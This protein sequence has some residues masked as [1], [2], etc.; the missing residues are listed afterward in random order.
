MS[1]LHVTY[2]CVA[3]LGRILAS[4]TLTTLLTVLTSATVTSIATFAVNVQSLVIPHLPVI[5]GMWA[6]ARNHD[7]LR[8]VGNVIESNSNIGSRSTVCRIRRGSTVIA[9]TTVFRYGGQK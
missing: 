6:F 1:Q 2:R 5:A 4:R 7:N 9:G 8:L 3:I